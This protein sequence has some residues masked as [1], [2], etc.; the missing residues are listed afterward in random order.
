MSHDILK[1]LVDLYA[2]HELPLAVEEEM[3][4]AATADPEL[5]FE[6]R[7]L[8]ETVDSIRESDKPVFT[9]EI[10]ERIL[11]KILMRQYGSQNSPIVDDVATNHFH[12]QYQLPIRS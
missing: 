4:V 10:E 11:N 7:S 1:K 2:A 9:Q 8:R 12:Y 6:M 5:A 3:E